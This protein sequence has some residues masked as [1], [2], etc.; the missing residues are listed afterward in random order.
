[1]DENHGL[2]TIHD[3]FTTYC[4]DPSTLMTRMKFGTDP[5]DT[6]NTCMA[7]KIKLLVMWSNQYTNDHMPVPKVALV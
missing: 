6:I 3:I 5:Q 1:M 7:N 2:D 4:E